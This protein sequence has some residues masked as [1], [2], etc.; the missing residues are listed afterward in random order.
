MPW[1][2]ATAFLHSSMV[3]ERRGGL[4]I[5]THGARHRDLRAD[6][7]RHVP[8][9]QR[10]G[11]ERPR[12]H[13]V[14]DRAVVRGRDPRR[15]RRLGSACS[16][17]GCRTCAD[18]RPAPELASRESAF[19]F[20]NVLFL[21]VTLV[22]CF[23]TLLPLV[24]EGATG[25]RLGLGAPY[26]NALNAPIFAAL[27]FLMAIGPALP[28]GG[29]SWR[30]LRDRFGL[31]TLL[32]RR[33]HAR[34]TRTAGCA[35]SRQ[36]GTLFLARPRRSACSG[37]EVV[38]G[39]A[40]AR[41]DPRRGAA[42]RRLAA[43]DPQPAPLRRLPRPCRHLRHGHR[44]RGQRH[45]RE[46]GERGPR[47]RARTMTI[48]ALPD[49]PRPRG[50]GAAPRRPAR[51]RARAPSSATPVRGRGTIATALRSYPNSTTAIATPARSDRS[52]RGP[53]P[54]PAARPT[55]PPAAPRSRPTS[56][57]SWHGSG[58]AASSSSP[59]PRSP[60]GRTAGARRCARPRPPPA[61]RCPAPPPS[62]EGA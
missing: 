11:P 16:C 28:W 24:I 44:D 4:R 34:G 45:W 53:L 51:D 25:G 41:P 57:R 33:R 46:P 26:F 17:G 2:T 48:G 50:G 32:A 1:L 30:T 6:P 61:S 37:D 21:A 52:R 59:V 22:V 14:G 3:A 23:G 5:F 49:H 38:R 10:R 36:L 18:H 20:N 42:D 47:A 9:A 7:A 19:L 43:G 54:H 15:A 55:P 8:D 56:T 40:V 62:A 60:P 27:L 29:A 39:D 31:P 12:L 58:S 35:A 13:R